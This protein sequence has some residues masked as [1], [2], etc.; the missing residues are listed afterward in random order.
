MIVYLALD[1]P[2]FVKYGVNGE[3]SSSLLIESTDSMVYIYNKSN[4]YKKIECN[5]G[6]MI[7]MMYL[8]KST[9]TR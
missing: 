3:S 8:Q 9:K 6:M 5:V 4:I 1:I 2:P 7:I